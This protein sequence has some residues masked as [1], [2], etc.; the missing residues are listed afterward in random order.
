MIAPN[1]YNLIMNVIPKLEH[2]IVQNKELIQEIS[3]FVLKL[4]EIF[5]G[6]ASNGKCA[7]FAD[8]TIEFPYYSFGNVKSHQHLEY[9]ELVIF[10]I[11]RSILGM[12]SRFVDAGGN[13]GLHS[14]VAGSLSSADLVYIEPDPKHYLEAKRRFDLNGLTNR[15]EM[16]QVALCSPE[17]SKTFI[18]VLDNTTG[19]HLQ[20]SK[21]SV[22]GPIET[23]TVQGSELNKFISPS[24]R[25]LA[26]IDIEGAESEVL[27]SLSNSVW[28]RLDCIVEITDLNAAKR[29]LEIARCHNLKISSQKISWNIA[30]NIEDLPHKWSE[31]SI[32]ISKYLTRNEFLHQ[33]IATVNN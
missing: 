31:G 5:F 3:D 24:S 17:E 16:H 21:E 6:A 32:F 26:K 4:N 18:R 8:S 9:R 12:Y 30:N 29:I 1:A 27:G 20:G 13:L 10:A 2:D 14:I 15:I 28:E 23:I 7:I 33:G 19:S 25:T 22:Y 11:Y